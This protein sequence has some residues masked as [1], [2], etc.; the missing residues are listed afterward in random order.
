MDYKTYTSF[1]KKALLNNQRFLLG[2]SKGVVGL[3]KA[4]TGKT[5]L[6]S[7]EILFY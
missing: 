6:H 3:S 4:F 5:K 1:G 2:Q 7:E